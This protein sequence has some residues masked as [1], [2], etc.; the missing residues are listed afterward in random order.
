MSDV[1]D[2][3]SPDTVVKQPVAEQP[4]KTDVFDQVAN[5]PFEKRINEFHTLIKNTPDAERITTLATAWTGNLFGINAWLSRKG[6][7][8]KRPTWFPK[9]EQLYQK[10]PTTWLLGALEKE[11]GD[12]GA[13][14]EAIK[15]YDSELKLKDPEKWAIMAGQVGKVASE[16]AL[17]PGK[18]ATKFALQTALQTPST[19]EEQLPVSEAVKQRA[20]QT[21]V[22]YLTGKALQWT[23]KITQPITEKV[24]KHF[25]ITSPFAQKLL[26][27]AIETPPVAGGF[28]ALTA[29]EGGNKEQVLE[30]GIQI[31]GFQALGLMQSGLFKEAAKAAVEFNP[32]LAKETTPEKLA[33]TLEKIKPVETKEPLTVNVMKQNVEK[34]GMKELETRYKDWLVSPEGI[35]EKKALGLPEGNKFE[36]PALWETFNRELVKTAP[37]TIAGQ[38]EAKVA[39]LTK[40]PMGYV[41]AIKNLNGKYEVKYQNGNLPEYPA[42]GEKFNGEFDTAKIARSSFEAW[43]YKQQQSPPSAEKQVEELR[44]PPP[45]QEPIQPKPRLIGKSKALKLGHQLP[46][47][48]GWDDAQRR[49]FMNGLVKKTSMKDMSL[50]EMRTVVEALQ[51]EVRKQGLETPELKLPTDELIGALQQKKTTEMG[52]IEELHPGKWRKLI[53]NAKNA[54]YRFLIGHEKI[55]RFLEGLDKKKNGP[56]FKT[57]WEPAAQ[58]DNLANEFTGQDQKLLQTTLDE[59]KIDV[60]ELM[61]KPELVS[62]TKIKL[63]PD[64]RIGTYMLSLNPKGVKNL[65]D[66]MGFTLTDLVEVKNSLTQQEKRVADFILK[67]FEN[68]WPALKQ[69]AAQAGYDLAKL[70]Q[71]YSYAPIMRKDVD[72]ELQPD[73]LNEIADQFIVPGTKPEA[74]MLKPR[75]PGAAGRLELSSMMMFFRNAARVN[76]FIQMA[77]YAREMSAILRNKDLR[78]ELNSKTY[79]QGTKILENWLRDTVRGSIARDTGYIGKLVDLARRKNVLFAL[80]RNIL[81]RSRQLLGTFNS[82]SVDPRMPGYMTKNFVEYSLPGGHKKLE[83][84]VYTRSLQMKNRD[85]ERDIKAVF[86]KENAKKLLLGK[87][88]SPRSM[89]GIAKTDK[90]VAALAWKSFYDMDMKDLKGDELGAI[91]FADTWTRRTQSMASPK[92]LPE[93]F[94]GG[95]LEKLFTT[96]QTETATLGNYWAHD[97]VGAKVRGEIGWRRF[98]YRLL[99]GY[100]LPAL[101]FGDINRGRIQQSGKEVAVDLATYPVAPFIFLGNWIQRMITGLQTGIIGTAGFEGIITSV[102]NIRKLLKSGELSE[103]EYNAAIRSLIKGG[104]K[105]VGGFTGKITAQDIRTAEGVYD[106]ATGQTQ[107]WRR[108]IWSKRALEQGQKTEQN[109]PTF[110]EPK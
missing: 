105:T 11:K 73:F 93:F 2:Q 59:I 101:L 78:R 69:A 3:I 90:Y 60:S 100:V 83:T 75:K 41:K 102:A 15:R 63:T 45:G 74:G 61:G 82:M 65:M 34:Y 89:Q 42:T 30:T 36:E 62:G 96:F 81:A 40:P 14:Y 29:L 10:V 95:S 43:W 70:K 1:F 23:G 86:N 58:K 85:F 97:I 98:S 47:V 27:T 51:A 106:L 68:Q 46:D 108:I 107:D 99:V 91:K 18:T 37:E 5:D 80:G 64:E 16:F 32:E 13:F 39:E 88:L 25:D 76:R 52:P 49:D 94:R 19:E 66:G 33:G 17:M 20:I 53:Y 4:V 24:A 109:E 8:L 79:G 71:E 87:R 56:F 21:G 6:L 54:G 84:F 38:P 12:T 9:N 104:A 110:V 31:L 57:F 22:S 55:E 35:A 67:H 26:Q 103:T 50:K 77:P 28:M 92:D 48:L 72:V 44:A 7:F